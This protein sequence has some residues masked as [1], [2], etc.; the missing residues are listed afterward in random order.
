MGARFVGVFRDMPVL[1]FGVVIGVAVVF[2]LGVGSAREA[3]RPDDVAPS[4]TTST[5]AGPGSVSVSATATAAS[6]PSF[7]ADPDA[8]PMSEVRQAEIGAAGRVQPLGGEAHGDSRAPSPA[9]VAPKP[10]GHGRRP[11]R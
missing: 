8:K 9:R 11:F 6:K 10:R 1:F 7:T 5:A 2:R 3:M 4:S